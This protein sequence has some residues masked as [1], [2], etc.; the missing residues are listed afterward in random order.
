MIPTF[1]N[2]R[3]TERAHV[4]TYLYVPRFSHDPGDD[5]YEPNTS[6]PSGCYDTQ[7]SVYQC[8]NYGSHPST[9]F[10]DSE[11]VSTGHVPGN[12]FTSNS[13]QVPGPMPS[14]IGDTTATRWSRQSGVQSGIWNHEFQHNLNN[15]APFGPLTEIFSSAAEAIGGEAGGKIRFDVP[16]T[17]GFLE[18]NYQA[19]REF[20]AYLVYGFRGVDTTFAG[21]SDDLVWR[22]AHGTDHSL[23]GLASRM[24]NSECGECLTKTWLAAYSTGLDRFQATM[25]NWRVANYVNNSS[26]AEGQYGFP[27]QFGFVPWR[28]VGNW[29][30]MD[31]AVSPND[32]VAIAPGLTVGHWLVGRDS[33]IQGTRC[34]PGSSNCV[35]IALRA[36]GSDYWV[37][38]TDATVR[39]SNRTFTAKFIPL[40]RVAYPSCGFNGRLMV[41][42]VA[43]Q[44]P[45]DSIVTYNN[46]W[47]HP[48]WAKS[49]V[50]PVAVDVDSLRGSADVTLSTFGTTNNA[51]LLVATL[52]DGVGGH[53][54]SQTSNTDGTPQLPYALDL[55][56]GNG[57]FPALDPVAVQARPDSVDRNPSWSPSNNEVVYVHHYT[58]KSQADRQ[59]T[60]GCC[61]AAVRARQR[62]R[63]YMCDWSPR[64]DW[65]VYDRAPDIN[66]P[67][68]IWAYNVNTH[69]NR[70]ITSHAELD[71]YPSFSPN[72]QQIAYSFDF[73]DEWRVELTV[74]DIAADDG[75]RYPALL[76]SIGKAPPQYIDQDRLT[77]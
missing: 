74:A 34:L 46:L 26:L 47:R 40:G 2:V 49:V 18:G 5:F 33:T 69:E 7:Y 75:G 17:F 15:N 19:W 24:N 65:V 21:R 1:A 71:V 73:A 64:G 72:G 36:F 30:D 9:F 10:S 27:P 70:Q 4:D 11:D 54:T 13:Q 3:P 51:V 6:Y 50:G 42:L 52:E 63:I 59:L 66:T 48:E 37:I 8:K 43:Y 76:E 61:H 41:S 55:R 25:H 38:K 45:V 23:L 22:W 68:D 35:P 29:R 60:N 67:F 16:Y 12:A 32:A 31:G 53:L 62:V 56:L 20:T 39:D 14:Q 77:A 44:A 28:D 58:N 57:S